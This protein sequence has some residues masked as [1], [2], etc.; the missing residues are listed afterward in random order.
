MK[1]YKVVKNGYIV[2]VGQ[3]CGGEEIDE[4]EY[5]RIISAVRAK[6]TAPDGY[7]YTLTDDLRWEIYHI[8]EEV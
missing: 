3:N 1:Y 7:D 2:L 5:K 8:S 4:A 6:P